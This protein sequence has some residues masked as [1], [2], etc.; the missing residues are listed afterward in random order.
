MKE[1]VLYIVNYVFSTYYHGK[2]LVLQ[3]LE[4]MLVLTARVLSYLEER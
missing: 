4:H 2:N 1:H 3:R